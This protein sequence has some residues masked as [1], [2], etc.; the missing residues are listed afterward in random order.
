M[1]LQLSTYKRHLPFGLTFILFLILCSPILPP[2]YND[3]MFD[4]DNSHGILVPFISLFFLWQKRNDI[5]WEKSR[6]SN[7]GLCF[8]IVS[9]IIYLIGYAGGI[10]VIPRLAMLG[11]LIS[12]IY[13]NFGL[14]VLRS[15]GFPLFF[16]IFMIPVP[17][18]I[19]SIV[20]LPLQ[21]MVTTISAFMIRDVF[22]L[23]V[24]REGNMLYFTN[25]SLEVAEACSGIRSLITFLMLGSIFAYISEGSN[26]GKSVFLIMAV[27]LA[28]LTNLLRVT[29]TG[30]L[31]HYFGSRVAKGFL[32]ELSGFVVLGIG[33]VM[34]ILLWKTI[35][36]VEVKINHKKTKDL[37]LDA[38]I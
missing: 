10:F 32:H 37:H 1:A 9:L 12:L 11:I 31:A 16:L 28:M 13:Y 36:W 15:I 29:G 23:P 8:L 24:F 20:S 18:S 33:L 7:V 35:G 5:P 2:L 19:L 4:S 14:S 27:P 3:W 22:L 21:T 25:T 30:V 38:K 34:M 6:S 17:Y 26:K